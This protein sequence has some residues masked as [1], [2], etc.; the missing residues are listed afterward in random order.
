MTGT[1]KST[2]FETLI[3]QDLSND[4]GFALLDPHG[5]LYEKVKKAASLKRQGL[6]FFDVRDPTQPIRFN[7]LEGDQSIET[8]LFV[9]ATTGGPWLS[10]RFRPFEVGRDR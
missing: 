4:E 1:G 10:W 7:P 5:D 2:L 8:I 3:R 9:P 6:A